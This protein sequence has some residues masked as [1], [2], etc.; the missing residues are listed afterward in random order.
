MDR[1]KLLQDFRLCFDQS[2]EDKFSNSGYNLL[3]L[4][5]NLFN[6][7]LIS[8]D[9]FPFSLFCSILRMLRPV[10]LLLDLFNFLDLIGIQLLSTELAPLNLF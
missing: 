4:P 5:V 7:S 2:L 8:L 3:V 1:L 10:F 9:S 6:I